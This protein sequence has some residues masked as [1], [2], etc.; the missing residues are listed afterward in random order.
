MSHFEEFPKIARWNRELFVTEKLDGTNAQVAIVP[1]AELQCYAGEAVAVVG[2]LSL[3]AGSRTR[4]LSR[5][6]DN[7]GF[8]S[9]VC[10][11]ASY[12]A[13]GLGPGRHYGEWWGQ[14]INRGYGLSR[15]RFSLFNVGRW[16]A[17]GEEPRLIRQEN[18][19]LPAKWTTPAPLCCDVVPV[20]WRGIMDD[21]PVFTVLDNLRQNGSVAAPGFM[22]P[23]G[24]VIYHAAAGTYF[25][26]TI[27]RD[28]VPKGAR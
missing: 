23:E 15:R 6:A 18:P 10:D 14:G 9:W 20:L 28:D 24:I 21:F 12:L 26:R 3:F 11:H 7:Y 5:Q 22:R 25:K 4:M 8:A 13:A 19:T 1:T 27:E 2:D 17:V 16:H